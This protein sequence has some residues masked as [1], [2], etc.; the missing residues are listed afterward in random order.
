MQVISIMDPQEFT[1]VVVTNQSI[2]ATAGMIND[3]IE[4]TVNHEKSDIYDANM[5]DLEVSEE[6]P[7]EH[8][9]RRAIVSFKVRKTII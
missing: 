9:Q 1:F 7:D 8:G 4:Q 5:E 2:L 3:C 6:A